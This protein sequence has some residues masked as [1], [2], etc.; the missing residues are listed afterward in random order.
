M[1]PATGGLQVAAAV[2]GAA[3]MAVGIVFFDWPTFTVLALYWLENVII[4][5]FTVLRILAFGAR[6][7]QYL[8]SL[9]TAAFFTV[10]YGL[11]C[12]VHGVFVATLFGGIRVQGNLVDAVLLMIGRV[13]GDRLGLLVIVAMVIAVALD[14]WRAWAAS[15]TGDPSGLRRIMAEPYGRIVVLHL[16]LIAGGFLMVALQLPSLAALLLVAFK[17]VYDLRLLR[18]SRAPARQSAGSQP[19]HRAIG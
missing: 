15:D 13:G 5:A 12:L 14:A 9:G 18:R 4:G 10:H 17:L 16:V 7:E 1:N 6:S 11:F 19:H 3:V 8:A 2:A